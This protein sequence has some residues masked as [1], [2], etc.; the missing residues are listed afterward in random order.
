MF[1]KPNEWNNGNEISLPVTRKDA[2]GLCFSQRDS[3]YHLSS[4]P[5]LGLARGAGYAELFS[6]ENHILNLIIKSVS[7]D[8]LGS[9]KYLFFV[10]ETNRD[11]II[12]THDPL[13]EGDDTDGVLQWRLFYALLHMSLNPSYEKT[14]CIVW[15]IQ[16]YHM[17]DFANRAH[18]KF[19]RMLFD[20][21][22]SANRFDAFF[23]N[24]LLT[25]DDK[26]KDKEDFFARFQMIINTVCNLR[27]WR[28]LKKIVLF[29]LCCSYPDLFSYDNGWNTYETFAK[30]SRE[31]EIPDFHSQRHSGFVRVQ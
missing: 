12:P 13:L 20:S 14:R 19:L 23:E 24:I 26:T 1:F 8:C 30:I 27:R 5:D 29:C 16:R 2:L 21:P 22:R 15:I 25:H 31:S 7:K 6:D 28:V 18:L 10:S 4:L 11:G 9:L 3:Y 17:M